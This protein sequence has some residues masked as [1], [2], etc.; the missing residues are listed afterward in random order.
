MSKNNKDTGYDFI[1]PFVEVFHDMS[2]GVVSV[3][4]D[5]LK[6]AY[7]KWNKNYFE[8]EKI[9]ERHLH[10]NK[11]ALKDNSIGYSANQKREL[12]LSEIDFSKHSFIVGAAGFGKTNLISLLQEHSLQNEKPVIFIDPKGDLEALETFRALCKKYNRS[13]HIF[14]EHYKKSVK[15]NPFREGSINQVADRIISSLEWSEQFYKSVAVDAL[16]NAL[17]KLQEN[18]SPFSL[19]NICAVLDES[20]NSK[21]TL[22]LRV[23]L[24][25]I[26]NSDFGKILEEDETTKTFM[27]IREEKS[28]LYIG[29]STQGYGETAYALGKMFLGELLYAS[30]YKL[31]NEY[32]SHKSMKDSISVFFDEFGAIVT[33]RFI[34]LENKCR[35]AG[36]QLF[37]A[38]QS[39]SDIDKIDPHL[40]LAILE[41]SSNFFVLKQRM[42]YGASMFANAI[43]TKVTKKYTTREENGSDTGMNSVREAN[44]LLVHP[45]I[46]KNLRVGQ[47]V[48]LRHNPTRL[49]LLN[50]RERKITIEREQE[51]ENNEGNLK[52]QEEK[53]NMIFN[54]KSQKVFEV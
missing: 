1:T 50:L 44:E 5:L 10:S 28:C 35:G 6:I 33:P 52:Q 40:T 31:I 17:K 30:Y 54:R 16:S 18:K 11:K 34:E 20:F 4:F 8:L 32:D 36:I 26:K 38:V 42:D 46:I 41:S 39:P 9:E 51:V 13:C 14:S 27:K 23:Q 19:S 2:V 12:N 3:I 47:C 45:D 7:K 43:G 22:G 37:M 49:D 53:N 48:L 25:S 29:L 15:L 21:E 24:N